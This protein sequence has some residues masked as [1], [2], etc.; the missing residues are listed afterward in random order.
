MD[1]FLKF[2]SKT[3]VSRWKLAF[4]SSDRASST[5]SGELPRL[6]HR[7]ERCWSFHTL[8]WMV[9]GPPTLWMKQEIRFIIYSTFIRYI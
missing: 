5:E 7:V 6:I 8:G 9:H 1:K 3:R 4:Q 2:R